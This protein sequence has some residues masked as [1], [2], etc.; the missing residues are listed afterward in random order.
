M[1]AKNNDH[2]HPLNEVYIKNQNNVKVDISQLTD[3]SK[4]QKL[5]QES[6]NDNLKKMVTGI[7][8]HE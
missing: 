4:M 1:G 6:I 8:T 5:I 7:N 3:N 2:D